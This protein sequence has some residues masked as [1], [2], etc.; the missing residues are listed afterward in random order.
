MMS[1]TEKLNVSPQLWSLSPRDVKCLAV[2]YAQRAL[3]LST[4]GG[5]NYSPRS[6]EQSRQALWTWTWPKREERSFKLVDCF[7][8]FLAHLSFRQWRW[9]RYDS[10]KLRAF[11]TSQVTLLSRATDGNN[12]R[13][14][15]FRLWLGGW[16]SIRFWDI[17]KIRV[18]K[19]FISASC[20]INVLSIRIQFRHVQTLFATIRYLS[21]GVES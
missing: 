11:S 18:S 17:F 14:E 6:G 20:C 4:Q 2:L 15:R 3:W 19:I 9:K 1:A 10:L 8:W 21:T 5:D 13:P 7:W 16:Q 12:S